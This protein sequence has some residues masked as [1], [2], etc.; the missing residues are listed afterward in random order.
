MPSETSQ[1]ALPEDH[2]AYFILDAHSRILPVDRLTP[3][4]MRPEGVS[5][6]ARYMLAASRGEMSKRKPI[7]VEPCGEDRWRVL[8][9][10]ST[11]EVAKLSGWKSIPCLVRDQSPESSTQAGA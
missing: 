9:G 8:D 5:N 11:F 4:R 6:A 1:P 10:N 3:T 7:D 2:P